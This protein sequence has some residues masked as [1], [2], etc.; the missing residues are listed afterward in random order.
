[1]KKVI[2]IGLAAAFSTAT[3]ALADDVTII[4][5]R[6]YVDPDTT[7]SVVIKER[8]PVVKKKIIIKEKQDD[9]DVTIKGS[10]HVD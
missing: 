6:T 10:V 8:K 4:K 5:K 9:P 7:G 2:A 1:M 3:I